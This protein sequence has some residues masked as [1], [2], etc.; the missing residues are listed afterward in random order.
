MK[1][2][3]PHNVLYKKKHGFG[4]PVALWFLQESSAGSARCGRSDGFAHPAARLLPPFVS[5]PLLKLHRGKDAH[6]YGEIL[7]YLIALELWHR[8]HLE[9][10]LEKSV[11]TERTSTGEL[12]AL[13]PESQH[14]VGAS[15][16]QKP[17]LNWRELVIKG[18]H[19]SGALYLARHISS[20]MKFGRTP[21]SRFHASSAS[22]LP[23]LRSSAIT[24]LASPEIPLPLRH[25]RALRLQMRFLRENYR[26]VSS[27]KACRELRG[28]A[29]SPSP[30][31]SL[32]LTTAI[33]A[34]T[35]SLFRFC[36]SIACPPLFYLTLESV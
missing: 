9:R 28:V 13:R 10:S 27:R 2:I 17:L 35:L 26:V 24:E 16:P 3:L 8:Q 33:A 14:W 29:K 4:V 6:F 34:P 12:P 1:A 21:R 15:I 5:G 31:S 25:Q 32:L 19:Y 23:S 7:W 36:K 20:P 18:M 11:Q 22:G 30:E